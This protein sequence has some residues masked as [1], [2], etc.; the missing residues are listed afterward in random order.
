MK[1]QYI[2]P[3]QRCIDI[4]G[5]QLCTGSIHSDDANSFLDGLGLHSDESY[6]A[7]EDE[8]L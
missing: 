3:T 5:C 2:K 7:E 1:K 4:E 8:L 6:D